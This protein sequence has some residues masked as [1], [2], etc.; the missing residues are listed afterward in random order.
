[1]L[2]LVDYCEENGLVYSN[3]YQ[4]VYQADRRGLPYWIEK[5]KN[6]YYIDEVKLSKKLSEEQC[7]WS[8]AT[9]YTYWWLHDWMNMK[10]KEIAV[11]MA[12]RSKIF[13]SESSWTM[14]INKHLFNIP[15]HSIYDDKR[16]MVQDFVVYG[17]AMCLA[18]YRDN[19]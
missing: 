19:Y 6:T 10:D 12:K 18:Y 14:F 16:R 4:S 3:T 17:T 1:M 11:E 8:F 15:T 13:T 2:S 9:T 7:A 5:Q